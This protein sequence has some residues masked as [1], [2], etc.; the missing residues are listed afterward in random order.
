M[1]WAAA[2]GSL[3]LTPDLGMFA[4]TGTFPCGAPYHF[5]ALTMTSAQ[6]LSF[7]ILAGTMVFRSGGYRFGDYARLGAPLTLLVLVAGVPA[8]LF[9]WP[10]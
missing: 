2:E 7:A 1:A 6:F 5:P 4:D 3:R 8:N 10:V 9:F